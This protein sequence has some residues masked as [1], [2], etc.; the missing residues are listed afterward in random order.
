MWE[1]GF[2]RKRCSLL[3]LTAQ[4]DLS[5][6]VFLFVITASRKSFNNKSWKEKLSY[7]INF[8]S[9]INEHDKWS[10]QLPRNFISELLQSDVGFAV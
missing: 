4:V 6:S 5:V 3:T 10:G 2:M 8:L 9:M 1:P 7:I